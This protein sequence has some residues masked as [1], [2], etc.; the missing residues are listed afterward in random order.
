MFTTV[1]LLIFGLVLVVGGAESILRGSTRLA[2]ALGVSP[3]VIG[4][5]IVSVGTS[6][7]E[8]AVGITAASEGRGM[9]AVGNIAGTNVFNILFILG[10][11]ALLRPLPLQLGSIRLD[12]PVMVSAALALI[13]M[14]S[15]GVLSRLDGAI[16]LTAAILYTVALARQSKKERS[17]AQRE[18]QEE[19]GRPQRMTSASALVCLALIVAGIAITVWGAHVLVNAAVSLARLVG[20]SDAII[21]LTIV[22]IGTSAP[23]FATTMISTWQNERDVAIGNLIGST[24]YNILAILGVTCLVTPG[25]VPVSDEIL[26]IDIPLAAAAALICIPV[27]ATGRRVSRRE[28]AFFVTVYVVYLTILLVWRT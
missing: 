21:G 9:L 20:V 5:T 11:S 12:L 15:D 10:L 2:A 4:L 22:A 17:A 27:F 25:G 13:V 3:M 7:P 16:L 1:V 24:S 18:F 28:G 26:W 6:A 8:L 23:E 14:S 19:Y